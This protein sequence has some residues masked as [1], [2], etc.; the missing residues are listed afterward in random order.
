MDYFWVLPNFSVRGI[1]REIEQ[2]LFNRRWLALLAS[3]DSLLL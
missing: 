1:F 3:S 2:D